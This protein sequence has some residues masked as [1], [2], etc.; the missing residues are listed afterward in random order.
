MS[1]DYLDA[2]VNS[3]ANVSITMTP[4]E[5][6]DFAEDIARTVAE[7]MSAQ[8]VDAIKDAMGDT[9]KY[10]TTEEAMRDFDIKLP[11]LNSWV[12]KGV[13]VPMKKGRKNIFLR[14]D[15]VRLTRQKIW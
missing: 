5:L 9:M 4:S 15:L 1:K 8:T 2:L 11:T 6:R 12:A 14:E 7:R 3:G 13:I 10:C